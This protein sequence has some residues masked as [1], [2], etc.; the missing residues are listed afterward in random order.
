MA[1]KDQ[2]V[3]ARD[4]QTEAP[5]VGTETVVIRV[6]TVHRFNDNLYRLW[7][8][9][10]VTVDTATAQQW[11]NVGIAEPTK[12]S[13]DVVPMRDSQRFQIESERR[14]NESEARQ[15]V[16]RTDLRIAARHGDV[17]AARS[18][19]AMGDVDAG[20]FRSSGVEGTPP[21][22]TLTAEGAPGQNREPNPVRDGDTGATASAEDRAGQSRNA[23]A[24]GASV[25]A[26]QT[27]GSS[28][29]GAL[30]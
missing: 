27:T 13:R 22:L 19:D 2:K 12:R 15:T 9:M 24:E 28:A 7:P 4:E 23:R 29:R 3:D 14:G 21:P 16:V 5:E 6:Q 30:S 8:G 17:A 25:P 10:E 20:D 1:V 11:R 26:R 18:L